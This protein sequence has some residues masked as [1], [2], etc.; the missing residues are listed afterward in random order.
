M[1]RRYLFLGT[2]ALAFLS[3]GPALAQPG[4]EAEL[5]ARIRA[6]EAAVAELRTELSAARSETASAPPAAAPAAP[7]SG[8]TVQSAA[9]SPSTATAPAGTPAQGAEGF[10]VGGTTIRLNGFFKASAAVSRYDDGDVAPNTFLRDFYLPQQIP[11]GGRREGNDF[12]AQAKQTRIWLTTATPLG[13]HILKSHLE[14]DFVTAPGLQGSER[15]TNGYNPAL[16]RAFFT[17]DDDLLFGQDWSTFQNVSALPE[18]TDFVGPTEGTVFVRQAQIRYTQKLSPQLGFALAVENPETATITT[19]SAALVENDDDRVPDIVARLNFTPP[20]GEFS[21]AAL[22]RQLSA[23]NG[24]AGG[25]A[26]G[27]GLS[28]AGKVPFGPDNR[29]DLRFMLSG[30]DGVGRYIGLNFAPD[31]VVSAGELE[32]V[33]VLAGFATLR[34]ALSEQLRS[35]IMGSFQDVDYERGL[36]PLASNESAWSV[37]GNLFYSPVKNFDLGIEYR[38]GVRRL[39]SGQEGQLDRIEGAAKYSF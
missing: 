5:E 21:L 32:T 34:I 9:A 26:F 16:R 4:R 35:T 18:T 28:F 11:V 12:D 7:A 22:A 23:D 8:G 15:T 3:P 29:H 27:Y 33:R 14:I 20:I 25:K 13:T 36:A 17:Y 37:A 30:G 10:R 19:A 24:A 6:L 1:K 31:A 2:T 39:L 38:H